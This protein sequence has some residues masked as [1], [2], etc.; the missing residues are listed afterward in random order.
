MDTAMDITHV[1]IFMIIS[2]LPANTKQCQVFDGQTNSLAFTLTQNTDKAWEMKGNGKDG[3]KFIIKG[4]QITTSTEG[5]EIPYN[6]QGAFKVDDKKWAKVKKIS[7][8]TVD[9]P[10]LDV[11]RSKK[12]ILLKEQK[13]TKEI[14]KITY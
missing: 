6:L 7:F 12:N 4:E 10:A 1:F 3:L 14:M 11:V 13:G 9:A 2:L 5:V 8:L